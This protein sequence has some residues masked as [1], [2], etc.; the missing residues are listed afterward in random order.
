MPGPIVAIGGGS[1]GETRTVETTEIDQEAIR[2]TG[3]AK[4]NVLFVPTAKRDKPEYIAAFQRHYG[5]TL[6]ATV[7]VLYLYENRPSNAEVKQLIDWA[8]LI[9]VGG[10][11][12]LRMLMRWRA[13]GVDKLLVQAHQKGTVMAGQSAGA[14]CWFEFGL[15]DCW[16]LDHNPDTSQIIHGLGLI[17][18]VCNPHYHT[19]TWRVSR[20]K[21][22]LEKRRLVGVGI[23]NCAA[24]VVEDDQYRVVTSAPNAHVYRTEWVNDEYHDVQLPESGSM[25][26][27]R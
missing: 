16:H 9:Y 1:I 12:P 27:V 13:L 18:G 25:N 6:G 4:P 7:K 24:L 14:E 23:D 26:D 17:P 19:E 11:N 8:D 10:G 5:E 21:L 3:K 20:L 15:T 22:L 2:L